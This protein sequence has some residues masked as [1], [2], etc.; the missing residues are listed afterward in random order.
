[1]TSEAPPATPRVRQ[2]WGRRVH[3]EYA[4]AALTQNFTLWL[5]QIGASPDLIDDGLR[6]V[7]D[8]LAHS[9]LSHQVF[10]DAGGTEL[11]PLDRTMLGLQP[12]RPAL[13]ADV[14]RIGVEMFCLG[15][16]VAVP[17]F[18]HMRAGCS[19][20][21]ARRALDRILRDEVRH[22][23]FGWSLLDWLLEM[24]RPGE[25]VAAVQQELPLLFAQLESNYGAGRS[26]SDQVTDAERAWGLVA[27]AE[28]AQL[29]DKTFERDWRPR[30]GERGIDPT[31][32]W[33][34]R[35]MNLALSP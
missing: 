13:E 24:H 28:Y 17:L 31:P 14:I 23:D 34:R 32:A 11:P 15:E 20:P 29:L 26:D 30:F 16:T 12:Q 3:A 22:R 21:S 2:E 25:I 18:S 1:M 9:R 19:A 6:I 27:T 33:Q 7:A 4:S 8:E 35:S 5:I 10:L